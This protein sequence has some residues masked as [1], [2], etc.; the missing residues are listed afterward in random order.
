MREVSY[1]SHSHFATLPSVLLGALS[2]L[3]IASFI[4]RYVALRTWSA[5][6]EFGRTGWIYWPTQICMSVTGM[7]AVG[8]LVHLL[9]Q[10]NGAV[11]AATFGYSAFAAAWVSVYI[12]FANHLVM[13][14]HSV[15]DAT[16]LT[17]VVA[18]GPSQLL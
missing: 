1:N 7:T 11:P 2:T 5:P 9:N 18:G 3:A 4:G 12:F 8:V 17:F 16:L 10:E 15:T 14:T 6:H 13:V